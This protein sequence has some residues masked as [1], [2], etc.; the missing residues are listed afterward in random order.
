MIP[1]VTQRWWAR[2][3]SSLEE[4][5][6]LK[7]RAVRKRHAIR[8]MSIISLSKVEK[9][10]RERKKSLCVMLSQHEY[11]IGKEYD[12]IY[13]QTTWVSCVRFSGYFP[14]ACMYRSTKISLD[15]WYVLN[16]CAGH[17]RHVVALPFPKL[18]LCDYRP[19]PLLKIYLCAKKNFE[20]Y[21]FI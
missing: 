10:E 7:W 12:Y 4:N 20:S 2:T 6:K 13:H 9:R 11:S 8:V 3:V 16:S 15:N 5:A 14:W 19:L 1:N 17:S 21:C 18:L